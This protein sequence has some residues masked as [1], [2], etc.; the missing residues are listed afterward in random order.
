MQRTSA[1]QP[2]ST[3]ERL[4]QQDDQ[5]TETAIWSVFRKMLGFTVMMVLAPIASFFISKGFIFEGL[6]HME[7]NSSYIY[8]ATVAV[9]IVHVILIAFLYV[10]FREDRSSE[11]TKVLTGKKD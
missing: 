8:A 11:K 6:F 9:I 10:A 5:A 4:I 3:V 1:L 2:T 7:D